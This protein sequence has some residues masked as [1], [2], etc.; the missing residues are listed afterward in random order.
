MTAQ[1]EESVKGMATI[2]FEGWRNPNDK[3]EE[4][5]KAEAIRS[6][7]S[8]WASKQGDAFLKN[9]DGS[10]EQIEAQIDSYVLG[11]EIIDKEINKKSKQYRMVLRVIIDDV[12]LKNFVNSQSDVGNADSSEKSYLA[13]IFVS[14]RQSSIKSFDAKVYKRE[15]SSNAQNGNEIERT[16]QSGLQYAANQNASKTSTTGGSTI[17]KADSIAYEVTSSD[18]IN[19]AM[20]EVFSGSGFE[21]V[22]AEY[23]EDESNGLLSVETFRADY[24]VGDDIS[25]E[26]RRNA[27]K[28]AKYLDIPYLAVGAL[29]IGLKDIDPATGNT[30][31]FVTVTGKVI[32]VTQRFPKTIAS[33]GPIQYAGLGPNQTVAERNGL[34]LAAKS[35][36]GDLVNQMNAKGVK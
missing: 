11:T 16:N 36:A 5:L 23:L 30:R 7:L 21:I 10:R 25:G 19:T 35:A 34:S 12:R 17:Q 24:S 33:V 6:A 3:D 27:V 29:D 31:V 14:R 4:T 13:F 9:Y 2:T 18:E 1:A 32:D 15:E 20:S 8:R 26:T 28:G 22:E